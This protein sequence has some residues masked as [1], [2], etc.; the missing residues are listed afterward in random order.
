MRQQMPTCTRYVSPNEKGFIEIFSIAILSFDRS[1]SVHIYFW[2]IFNNCLDGTNW[3]S[4]F[5]HYFNKVL[6]LSKKNM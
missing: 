5:M 4:S 2:T 6:N 3:N 1:R